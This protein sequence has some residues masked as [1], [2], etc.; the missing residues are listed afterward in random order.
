M[1]IYIIGRIV[2][3]A[4]IDID[5]TDYYL[6]N[7]TKENAIENFKKDLS[8]IFNES[9]TENVWVIEENYDV[10]EF[11]NALD[12]FDWDISLEDREETIEKDY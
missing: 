5:P 2:K 9:Q 10:D 4:Q 8:E 11:V 3:G 6:N 1:E 7:E 12:E